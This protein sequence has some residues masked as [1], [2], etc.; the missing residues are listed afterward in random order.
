MPKLAH[1][2]GVKLPEGEP[3][4][5]WMADSSYSQASRPESSQS[6]ASGSSSAVTTSSSLAPVKRTALSAKAKPF[7]SLD[8]EARGALHA[9]CAW[10]DLWPGVPYSEEQQDHTCLSFNHASTTDE[11]Q[12]QA[13]LGTASGLDYERQGHVFLG[14]A[15]ALGGSQGANFAGCAPFSRPG[16]QGAGR[17][18]RMPSRT[19]SPVSRQEM[20]LCVP[21]LWCAGPDD[22]ASKHPESEQSPRVGRCFMPALAKAQSNEIE[23]NQLASCSTS[24]RSCLTIKNTFFDYSCDDEATGQQASLKRTSSA[25][26]S[27]DRFAGSQHDSSACKPCAY[28]FGKEDGCRLGDSCKF[29]HLCPPGM[30]KLKKKKKIQMMREFRRCQQSEC[31]DN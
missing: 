9:D 11:P 20:Q 21:T 24:P 28:F 23:E 30:M 29:C 16:R 5:N 27:L 19:P 13:Y 26:G 6:I 31:C 22:S 25:P 10:P 12:E 2:A 1:L 14:L 8:F 3:L 18:L 15:V 7:Q 17:A 4:T